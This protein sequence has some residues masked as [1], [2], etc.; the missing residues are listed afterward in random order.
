[1]N[2]AYAEGLTITDTALPI[3]RRTTFWLYEPDIL[4]IQARYFKA[5]GD[6]PKSKQT[7]QSAY[8]KADKMGYHWA[9]KE[10]QE[11]I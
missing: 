9:K 10:A 7:A 4:N 6:I 3:I 11:L 8:D 1:M 5:I 2:E